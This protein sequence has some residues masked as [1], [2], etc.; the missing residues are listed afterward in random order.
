MILFPVKFSQPTGR[1]MAKSPPDKKTTSHRHR[2]S[3]LPLPG[4][5]L[6]AR[7]DALMR[8]TIPNKIHG[9]GLICRPQF[10]TDIP[11]FPILRSQMGF[12]AR[13]FRSRSF[14]SLASSFRYASLETLK[15]FLTALLIRSASVLPGTFGAGAG[16]IYRLMIPL[17]APAL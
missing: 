13:F 17:E 14:F 15:T 12:F 7:N 11:D 1:T 4:M 6:L 16:F 3:R 2:T 10:Q 9:L 5:N 8:A